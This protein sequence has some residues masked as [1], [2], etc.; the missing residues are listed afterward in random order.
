MAK[1]TWVGEDQD[2]VAGPSFTTW[3]GMKFD[4]DKPVDI[5]DMHI[6]AK[7]K[8]NKFFKVEGGPGRPPNPP[9]EA[10]LHDKVRA[11]GDQN[12]D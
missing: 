6:L 2:D 3:Q 9:K 4:K 11:Y 10:A 12:A 5:T 1:V 8:S 7:A